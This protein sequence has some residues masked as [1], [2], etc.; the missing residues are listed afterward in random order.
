M[1]DRYASRRSASPG[2][3]SAS[4]RRDRSP[5]PSHRR[6]DDDRGY[7][8]RDSGRRGGPYDDDERDYR[9][10]DRD[11]RGGGRGRYDDEDEYDRRRSGGGDGGRRRSPPPAQ[12]GGG[13][14][15]RRRS[16]SPVGG[17]GG[18]GKREALPDQNALVPGGG[19][20]QRGG[21]VAHKQPP[22]PVEPDFKPSGALA[23]ETNT[24]NGV[25]LKYSEPA[26]ARK[27]VRNWRLYVFKGKEQVELFHVHRQSCYLFGR[28]RVVVDIPVDHPSA[29]K[30]HAVLQYRQVVERNEFGDTKSITKPFILDLESAN[31][32]LVND[33][34]VPASRYY[35]LRSG[36]VI[37]FA[38]STREYVLLV[39]S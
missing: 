31:G 27:P 8:R 4:Y 17:D 6:R 39:E 10:R 2:P 34:T 30:Q 35:E 12:S 24:L 38:F 18:W 1:P 26:E 5:P 16:R 36:D 25:V 9:D 20:A 15:G 37:K 3:S 32:T 11:R 33:E 22:K 29:S 14:S 13:G 23:A 21:E 19:G 28:D 7:D